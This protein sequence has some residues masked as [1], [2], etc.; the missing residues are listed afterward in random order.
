MISAFTNPD[1]FAAH[2][3]NTVPGAHRQVA[4]APR[5]QH[6]TG[7]TVLIPPVPKCFFGRA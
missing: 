7:T 1:R 2:F 3:N 5:R 4:V 6:R